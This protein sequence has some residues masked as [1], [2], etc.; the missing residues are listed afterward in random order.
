MCENRILN[1]R[2]SWENENNDFEPTE[3]D[4]ISQNY[5]LSFIVPVFSWI[6]LTDI[7]KTFQELQVVWQ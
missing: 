7:W 6:F 1:V 5:H 2:A 3:N 4:L